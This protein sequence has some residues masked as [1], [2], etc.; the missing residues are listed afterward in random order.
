VLACCCCF[1]LLQHIYTQ[2]SLNKI[3][4]RNRRCQPSAW[5]VPS[6]HPFGQTVVSS[7]AAPFRRATSHVYKQMNE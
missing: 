4:T 7:T 1:F 2:W 5:P 6:C 3:K